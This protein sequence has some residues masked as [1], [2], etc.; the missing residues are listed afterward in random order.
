MHCLAHTEEGNCHL[1]EL[2]WAVAPVGIEVG[3]PGTP[4][5]KS[6]GVQVPARLECSLMKVVIEQMLH[7]P[8]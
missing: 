1:G 6:V 3:R 4:I 2:V 8:P 5:W 7:Q